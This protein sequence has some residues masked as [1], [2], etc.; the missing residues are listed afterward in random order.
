[1]IF[2]LSVFYSIF[3]T[4]TGETVIQAADLIIGADGA[5]STLRS[6]MQ[7][8]PL[9]E[10]SQTYIDHGYLELEI[11]SEKGGGMVPNHLHIWPRGDMMM[12]ALPNHDGSWTV[13]LFM[14]FSRFVLP[15]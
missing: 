1:M 7:Q 5:R 8:L 15:F 6:A 9:F 11:S 3:S 14:P 4:K 2:L 13:T 10:Y 12:I